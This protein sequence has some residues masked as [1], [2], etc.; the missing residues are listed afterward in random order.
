LARKEVGDVNEVL[1][2]GIMS[3]SGDEG[4]EKA[5]AL[6]RE[7]ILILHLSKKLPNKVAVRD[8]LRLIEVYF[9][10]VWQVANS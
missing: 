4:V 2:R 10:K 8:M 7:F 9:K 5:K 1:D 3:P 6:Q